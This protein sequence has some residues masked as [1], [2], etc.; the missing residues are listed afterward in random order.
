MAKA[1]L[2]KT[3]TRAKEKTAVKTAPKAAKSPAPKPAVQAKA[4]TQPAT[5]GGGMWKLLEMK[6]QRL[7]LANANRKN[8]GANQAK[9][10]P[11][12]HQS[13]QISKFQGPRRR[14]A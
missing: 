11:F 12:S 13:E 9:Q 7:K 6:E 1:P 10:G 3:Q 5:P 14:A 8:H 2:K 4:K